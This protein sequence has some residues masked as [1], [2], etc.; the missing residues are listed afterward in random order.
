M[1]QVQAGD[2]CNTCVYASSPLPR[3]PSL[4]ELS[5]CQ[6]CDLHETLKEKSRK[7]CIGNPT[8]EDSDRYSIS[9]AYINFFAAEELT[10]MWKSRSTT[11]ISPAMARVDTYYPTL[12][13]NLWNKS[14]GANVSLLQRET[15]WSQLQGLKARQ[16]ILRVR[17]LCWLSSTVADTLVFFTFTSRWEAGFTVVWDR[18]HRARGWSCWH[19]R[20][21]FSMNCIIFLNFRKDK[22]FTTLDERV[23]NRALHEACG[24]ELW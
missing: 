22:S 15:Q 12:R 14:R 3:I 5:S 10:P 6:N 20:L 4:L 7:W 11:C 19:Q 24:L 2:Y 16:W 1:Q 17:L 21:R 18:P 13:R 8:W 23:S 9:R